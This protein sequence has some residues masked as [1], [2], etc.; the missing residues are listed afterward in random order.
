MKNKI[1][2]KD[3]VLMPKHVKMGVKEKEDL[4][5]K[6]NITINELPKI[7][8]TDP[9]ISK[10]ETKPGDV[11]KVIRKSATAEE[12]LFYRCVVNV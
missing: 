3:H 11:I 4:L 6:Y 10:L 9:A 8:K 2:V 1:F 5:K 12:A 7:K